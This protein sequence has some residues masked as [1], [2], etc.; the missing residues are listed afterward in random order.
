MVALIYA[1]YVD[2]SYI[3]NILDIKSSQT[4]SV[5]SIALPLLCEISQA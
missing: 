2:P 3:R 4:I 5:C 1:T